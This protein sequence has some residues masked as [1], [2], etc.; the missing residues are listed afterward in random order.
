MSDFTSK[1]GDPRCIVCRD[2]PSIFPAER[3]REEQ[4]AWDRVRRELAEP[5]KPFADREESR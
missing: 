3:A 4:E 2:F 1:C 5:S